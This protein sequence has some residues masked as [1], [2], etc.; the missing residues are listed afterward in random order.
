MFK[1]PNGT[2]PSVVDDN[3]NA[4]QLGDSRLD[5][6][7]AMCRFCDVAG[8]GYQPLPRIA[9]AQPQ[10]L[11]T[12]ATPGRNNYKGTRSDQLRCQIPTNSAAGAS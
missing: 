2:Y 7:V 8:N 4:A 12:I 6:L 10:L 11:Q 1:V 5:E 9:K 3:I